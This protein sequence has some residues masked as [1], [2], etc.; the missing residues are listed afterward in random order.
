MSKRTATIKFGMIE[1][2][3]TGDYSKP[4]KETRIDPPHPAEFDIVEVEWNGKDVTELFNEWVKNVRDVEEKCI[5]K[6]TT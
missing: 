4:V 5:E 3:V 6:L 2:T 1:L